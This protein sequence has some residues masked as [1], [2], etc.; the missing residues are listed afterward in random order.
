VLKQ[1]YKV[2]PY[3]SY[4]N[5][6]KKLIN[7]ELSKFVSSLSH[8]KLHPQLEYALLSKGKRLRPLLVILSAQSVG[9]EAEK[10]MPLALAFELVHTATL[11]HDDIIDRDETRRG[12]PALHVKWSVNDAILTGDAMIALAVN[13][14][15]SYGEQILKTVSNSALELCDGEHLDISLSLDSATEEEYFLKI[16]EKSA[17]LF[18]ASAYSGALAGGG[19]PSEIKSLSTFGENFGIAYQLKDDLVDLEHTSS[20]I[21]RDLKRGRVTLPLIHLYKT[22]KSR[23][24]QQ[25]KRDFQKALRNREAFNSPAAKRIL[26]SLMNAGSLAYAEQKMGY[27]LQQAIES[28]KSLKDTVYKEHLVQMANSLR[29]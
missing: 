8:L 16:R 17:S 26:E 11:V 5:Q 23:E 29:G 3:E 22:S 20:F 6:T 25:L 19:S 18:R 7:L 9:G 12:I 1:Q 27:Y 4:L 13:L 2:K 21:S 28:I 15:S 10:V 24:R 14:A